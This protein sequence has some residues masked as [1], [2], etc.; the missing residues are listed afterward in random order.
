MVNKLGRIIIGIII[1]CAL[2]VV[3]FMVLPG[4]LKFPLKAKLQN[5]TNTN[6]A[7]IVDAVKNSSVPKHKKVTF[8]QMMSCTDSPAWT[9]QKISV[10]DAGNGMYDVF[11]DGYKTTVSWPNETNDDSMVTHTDAHVRIIFHVT[12][13]NSEIKI[14]DDV[15]EEGKVSYPSTVHIDDYDYN[16]TDESTYYQRSLDALV[17]MS[18]AE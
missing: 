10:D 5:E 18:G 3:I 12:K 11:C 7:V 1:I 4:N 14:G 8:D 15:V 13:N 16:R 17:K 6:Y 2:A 9:I